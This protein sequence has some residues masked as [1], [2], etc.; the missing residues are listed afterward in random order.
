MSIVYSYESKAFVLCLDPDI[1]EKQIND[2]I[3]NCPP[4]T[5][6][7]SLNYV[8]GMAFCMFEYKSLMPDQ[9]KNSGAGSD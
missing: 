1:L 9:T 7:V 5:R 4:E 3:V 6:L 2:H 8:S